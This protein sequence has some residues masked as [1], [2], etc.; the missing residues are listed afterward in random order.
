MPFLPSR[1]LPFGPP[2]FRLAI[3]GFQ[4]SYLPKVAYVGPILLLPPLLH[5]RIASFCSVLVN[6]DDL[7]RSFVDFLHMPLFCPKQVKLLAATKKSAR[8]FAAAAT[9]LPLSQTFST[10]PKRTTFTTLVQLRAIHRKPQGSLSK[11]LRTIMAAASKTSPDLPKAE[12]RQ[13]GKSGLRVSVP[14]L[15]A[16]SFGDKRWAPWV[17]EEDEV[18]KSCP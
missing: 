16:M 11:G 17:I 1:T 12:Y 10:A 5:R 4:S 13:L 9:I 15:G 18:R 14:I 3:H 6:L 2:I 7:Q 8:S